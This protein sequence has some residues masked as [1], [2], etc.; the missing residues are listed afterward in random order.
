M[1]NSGIRLGT[2]VVAAGASSRM[3]GIDKQLAELEGIPAVIRAL[4]PF[5]ALPEVSEIVLVCREREIP[6]LW[7]LLRHF[8][9]KKVSRIVAGGASRQESVFAGVRSLGECGY[10]AVHDGARAFVSPQVI[11]DCLAL[12]VEKR[13]ALAAVPVKDTIKRA[14]PKGDVLETPPRDSLYIA[15]TPQIFERSLYFTAMERA[16]EAG[17]EY[18][19]DCQLVEALGQRCFL[20]PGSY[21]NFKITTPEDLIMAQAIAAG[22]IY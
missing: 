17:R 20:S 19:D 7:E 11:L 8:A 12:A 18:T 13:A 9:L 1:K 3:N 2:V 16:V 22:E 5:D 21:L 6:H 15:Q 4:Q 10:I 14:G